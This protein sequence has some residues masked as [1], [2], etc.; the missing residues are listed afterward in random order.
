MVNWQRYYEGYNIQ[1]RVYTG[2]RSGHTL[3]ADDPMALSTTIKT[4]PDTNN[5]AIIDISG[6]VRDSL[7]PVQNELC[8][9]LDG[10]NYHGNDTNLFTMFYIEYAEGYLQSDGVSV[11]AFTDTFT[12]DMLGYDINYFYATYSALQFQD[13]QGRSVGQYVIGDTDP[14]DVKAKFMTN[15]DEPVMYS[16]KEFDLAIGI[17]LSNA[18]LASGGY[19]LE[20]VLTQFQNDGSQITQEI[21]NVEQSDEGVYRFAF[22]EYPLNGLT[23]YFT[24]YLRRST[25]TI[26]TETKTIRVS[27]ECTYRGDIYLRWLNPLGGFDGWWFNRAADYIVNVSDRKT[28]RRDIYKDF[29]DVFVGGDTQDDYYQTTAKEKRIA[30]SNWLSDNQADTMIWLRTSNKVYECFSTTQEGCAKY[31]KRTVLIQP[32]ETL[33]RSDKD[34]LQKAVITFE[35]TDEINVPGQ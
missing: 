18:D 14:D 31:K 7:A 13:A 8:A 11:S 20:Y 15:F 29:D 32:E 30:R 2:I 33:I 3:A 21:S 9:V 25:G 1:V 23:D 17:G 27:P 24:F 6:V 19:G 34:K 5:E 26:I 12:T 35:Y 22:S 4:R 10:D 28:I 16:D